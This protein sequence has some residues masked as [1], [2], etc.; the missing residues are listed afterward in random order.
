M[1]IEL[2]SVCVLSFKYMNLNLNLILGSAET[3]PIY[4]SLPIIV[5]YYKSVLNNLNNTA[6]VAFKLE[7]IVGFP[8]KLTRTHQPFCE[9]YYSFSR[10]IPIPINQRVNMA[11][12]LFQNDYIY[13]FSLT[14]K[15]VMDLR[16]EQLLHISAEESITNQ[17]H[18]FVSQAAILDCSLFQLSVNVTKDSVGEKNGV[19]LH[20]HVTDVAEI[21]QYS[22]RSPLYD[23]SE[24]ELLSIGHLLSFETH[25]YFVLKVC[26]F[27]YS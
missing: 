9:G 17:K 22:T 1:Y 5:P 7:G 19:T 11:L 12:S 23:V 4:L 15:D 3:H 16:E 20:G 14:A 10:D 21:I 25:N 24:L 26:F 6:L 13:R 27:L 18:Q 2:I 8:E